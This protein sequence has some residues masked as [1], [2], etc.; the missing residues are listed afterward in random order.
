MPDGSYPEDWSDISLRIR[1]RSGGQCEC[2]GQ[3]GLHRG[4]RCE[5]QNGEDAKWASGRVCLT[6]AHLNHYPPDCREE[7]LL[8]LCNTCHLRYDQCLH[9][10]HAFRN[11]RERL[12]VRD[13]FEN[14]DK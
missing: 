3:C 7:N 2:T 11:R 10:E 1:T 8:A 6:V 4:D 13:M 14:A 12:A 9:T 5:E